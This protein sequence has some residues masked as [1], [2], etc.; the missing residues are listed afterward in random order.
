[1]VG[2][3]TQKFDVDLSHD[4][5]DCAYLKLLLPMSAQL[6]HMSVMKNY[7]AAS[8]FSLLFFFTMREK[9]LEYL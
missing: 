3:V 6:R 1:M 8:H 2:H 7:D 9:Q 4:A 5:P